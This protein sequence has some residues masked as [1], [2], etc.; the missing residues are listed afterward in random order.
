MQSCRRQS[1]SSV[2]TIYDLLL[3][4]VIAACPNVDYIARATD[5]GPAARLVSYLCDFVW[6]EPHEP[7][8]L[9]FISAFVQHYY[10]S[11]PSLLEDLHT[12]CESDYR[13]LRSTMYMLRSIKPNQRA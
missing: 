11:S 2:S 1:S 8:F 12:S 7:K 10:M 6:Q 13:L 5:A 9:H 4:Q 3:R